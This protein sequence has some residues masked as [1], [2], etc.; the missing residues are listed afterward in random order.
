MSAKGMSVVCGPCQEPQQTCS[1]ICSCGKVAQRPVRCLDPELDELQVVRQARLRVD[2]VPALGQ[3][4]VVELDGQAGVDDGLVF[5]AHR[6]GAGVEEFLV[7]AVVLV[8]HA[9][10]RTGGE[11]GDEP[12]GEAGR[13]QAGLEVGDVRGHE[14]LARVR[15]RPGDLRLRDGSCGGPGSRRR[16]RCRPHRTSAGPG[17]PGR[18][19]GRCGPARNGA[20]WRRPSGPR[21]SV[22]GRR[23]GRRSNSTRRRSPRSWTSCA[24]TRRHWGCR[25]PDPSGAGRRPPPKF[26]AGPG[27]R[28]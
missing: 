25:C 12:L 14:L 13:G 27:T 1:R 4:R 22:P 6:V 28:A 15:Q 21:R 5:L 7:A 16:G 20:P 19:S 23:A 18:T 8:G 26:R 17:G 11:G 2:L 9:G 10:A 24:R 3:G